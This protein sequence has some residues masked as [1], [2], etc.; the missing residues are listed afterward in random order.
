MGSRERLGILL[1]ALWC[2]GHTLLQLAPALAFSQEVETEARNDLQVMAS[3]RLFEEKW[4]SHIPWSEQLMQHLDIGA[5][6]SV[7]NPEERFI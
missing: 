5:V 4:L 7:A 6:G 1:Q 2:L 3:G